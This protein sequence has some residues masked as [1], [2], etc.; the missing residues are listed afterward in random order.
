MSEDVYAKL[1]VITLNSQGTS[2]SSSYATTYR[3]AKYAM[4]VTA[5][6]RY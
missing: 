2:T 5:R 4:V 6:T 1:V 3:S